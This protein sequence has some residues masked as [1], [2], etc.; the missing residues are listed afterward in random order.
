MTNP[1]IKKSNKKS[2]EAIVNVQHQQNNDGNGLLSVLHDSNEGVELN[3]DG[4][5]K[6]CF[7]SYMFIY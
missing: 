4:K 2:S 3:L 6:A 1:K 7:V 5:L